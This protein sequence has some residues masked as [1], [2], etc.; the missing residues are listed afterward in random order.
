MKITRR[1][2]T[3]E[4]VVIPEWAR[5][6]WI[7]VMQFGM[8]GP[9]NSSIHFRVCPRDGMVTVYFTG[10]NEDGEMFEEIECA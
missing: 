4:G 3:D 6:G 10:Q 9:V 2:K 5:R 7:N 8:G 1:K